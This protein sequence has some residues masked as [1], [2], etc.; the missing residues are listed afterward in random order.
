[1]SLFNVI[2]YSGT[3]LNDQYEISLLPEPLI[4]SFFINCCK[5]SGNAD[6]VPSPLNTTESMCIGL[7]SWSQDR[8]PKHKIFMQTLKEYDDNL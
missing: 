5:Y 3:D 1:M 2:K 8:H 6:Y 7:A 4:I